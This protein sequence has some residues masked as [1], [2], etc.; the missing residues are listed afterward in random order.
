MKLKVLKG[1]KIT[2]IVLGGIY[3]LMLIF[4]FP[5]FMDEKKTAEQI[6]KIHATKLT[7][8]DV[9]GDNL[10]PDPGAQAD[11]TIA[12]ID[13]NKNGI[14]DDV[15]LAI[16]K[17]YPKSAKI[18]MPLLQYALSMQLQMTLLL[19]NKETV[20]ATIE[21]TD[22]RA[23]YCIWTLS[24]RDDIK[25]F[26]KETDAYEKFVKDLQI[27]NEKRGK[28]LNGVYEKS[29]S[30]SLSSKGCDLDPATLPN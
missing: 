2:G 21:D 22:S 30:A 24:S 15:E 13:A 25:K 26:V 4:R 7:L 28:Y 12:G 18:R 17:E 9:M 20:T 6:A 29:G 11:K 14:R 5:S 19:I 8:A 10:P 16:F 27:N 1:V 3:L 23:F